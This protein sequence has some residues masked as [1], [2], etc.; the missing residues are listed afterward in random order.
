MDK[1]DALFVDV[2]HTDTNLF[3]GIDGFGTSN[4]SGHVDFWPNGGKTQPGCLLPLQQ[5]LQTK[6]L[7]TKLEEKDLKEAFELTRNVVCCD[8]NRAQQLFTQSIDKSC[9][10]KAYPCNNY[11]DFL[12]G[13][14]MQCNGNCISM[15]YHAVDHRHIDSH[16]GLF[17]TTGAEKP[18]CGK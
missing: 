14:C 7:P 2:I 6:P 5:Q 4:P 10:L 8:H 16:Q 18:F 17:I 1:T 3:I 9:H 15:G 13:E 11:Q 12:N